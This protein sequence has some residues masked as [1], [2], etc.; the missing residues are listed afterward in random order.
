MNRLSMDSDEQGWKFDPGLAQRFAHLELRLLGGRA[1]GIADNRFT[2]LQSALG[3][4][5]CRVLNGNPRDLR[6]ENIARLDYRLG[7]HGE[8]QASLATLLQAPTY[9]IPEQEP[10]LELG[11]QPLRLGR[12]SPYG[13]L[14]LGQSRRRENISLDSIDTP[15]TLLTLSH[16]PANKTPAD[17]KANLSTSSALD[18]IQRGQAPEQAE[19]ITS[20]HFDLDGLASVYAFLAPEH[21]LKHR[22]LLID[23]ARLGDFA[24]GTSNVALQCGFAL[25][26]LASRVS[27]DHSGSNDR[28]LLARFAALLPQMADVL[29]RPGRYAELY[30]P[31]LEQL[32]RSETL[33][34]HPQTRIEEYPEI[35]LAVLHLPY[36]AGPGDYLG[37][38]PVAVHNRSRCGVLALVSP[39]RV[40]IRQRYESW[41]ERVSGIPRPRRDLAIFARALQQA[42]A[43]PGQWHY[44]GVQEIMP[45]L[46]FVAER[47]SSLSVSQV[48]LELRQFLAQAPVAWDANANLVPAC[49]ALERA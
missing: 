33:L 17:Y 15:A 42:E 49:R 20:D 14:P 32:Q 30:R 45:G 23:I 40:E 12:Q 28:L 2:D 38:M 8:L 5:G 4:P 36:A 22:Q 44:P 11:L 9:A 7:G 39:G 35:D 46:K 10:V 48:L 19:V 24:R 27:S 29:E 18:F 37:L 26:A 3:G 13:F 6:L 16:W 47:P 25:N 34:A 43:T 41:V 21:A 31:A 1:I